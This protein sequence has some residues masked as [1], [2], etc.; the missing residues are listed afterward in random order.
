MVSEIGFKIEDIIAEL[1]QDANVSRHKGL[2]EACLS[3]SG[4]VTRSIYLC[5]EVENASI[6]VWIVTGF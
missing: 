6:H 3:A 5:S 4:M 1:T 2:R